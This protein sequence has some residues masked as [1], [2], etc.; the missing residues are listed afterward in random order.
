MASVDE[1][2][3]EPEAVG[4]HARGLFHLALDDL[5]QRPTRHVG[6]N[7]GVHLPAPFQKAEHDGL[8]PRAAAPDAPHA[9]RA[10]VA[11]VRL[12]LPLEGAVR[13]TD[14][15]YSAAQ[16]A[17]VLVHGVAVRARQLGGGERRHPSAEEPR[18]LPEHTLREMRSCDVLVPR[19]LSAG[20]GPILEPFE[21]LN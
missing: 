18:Q 9:P 6:D 5:H 7:L 3:V 4:V 17:V 13:L 10:E 16:H 8:A 2:V 11:L 14:L 20:H 19:L 1:V 12:H 21:S 15:G